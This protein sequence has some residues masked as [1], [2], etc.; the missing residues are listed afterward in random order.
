MRSSPIASHWYEVEPGV[1][2]LEH[3]R[4]IVG[5]EQPSLRY[6]VQADRTL[7]LV[8]DFVVVTDSGIPHRMPLQIRF[9]VDY[10]RHE[11]TAHDH[12]GRFVHDP[13]HHFID[14][15][16]CLW[17]RLET[18]WRREDPD[19]L[20]MFLDELVIFFTR[21]LVW[22]SDPGGGYPGPARAHGYVQAIPEILAERLG[23]P[24]G[25][26]WKMTR[27]LAGDLPRSA[28]CPCG[29][30][31]DLRQCHWRAIAD[32]RGLLDPTELR[33]VIELLRK[34]PSATGPVRREGSSAPAA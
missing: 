13:D 9:K 30:G 11:P 27:A 4:E 6:E 8:G 7:W 14:D 12:T 32:F 5:R 2:R 10:P 23:M 3:D 33:A 22:E 34:T 1:A 15:R 21:Q 29:S 20:A 19:A 28:R 26:L 18:K 17:H 25:D 16:V 24:V 31:R